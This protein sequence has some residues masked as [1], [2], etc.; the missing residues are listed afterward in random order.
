MGPCNTSNAEPKL[1]A[2]IKNSKAVSPINRQS[3]TTGTSLR[4]FGMLSIGSMR[5]YYPMILPQMW[6]M[7]LRNGDKPFPGWKLRKPALPFGKPL[8]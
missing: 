5:S 3:L 2:I 1:L 4:S 7:T 6:R 8:R